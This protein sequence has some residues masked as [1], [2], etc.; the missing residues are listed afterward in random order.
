IILYDEP[1]TGLDVITSREISQLILEIQK[2]YNTGS[3]IITHDMPCAKITANRIVVLQNG[4]FAAEGTY[5][6][7]ENHENDSVR[8]FFEF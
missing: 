2:K 8:S 4:K 3:I 7:L 6:E 5:D 1:T